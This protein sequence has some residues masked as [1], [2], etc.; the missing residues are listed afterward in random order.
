MA[1]RPRGVKTAQL[2]TWN[3][4][5]MASGGF[6]T[7]AIGL[8]DSLAFGLYND[9]N[10]GS[11]IVLWDLVMHYF[12]FDGAGAT[13]LIDV[14][15]VEGYD[16]NS[17]TKGAPL[18]A[19]A[20]ALAGSTWFEHNYQDFTDDYLYLVGANGMFQWNHDWPLGAIPPGWSL[21]AI[22]DGEPLSLISYNFIWEV[23]RSL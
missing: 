14:G 16:N 17:L 1:V 12:P 19:T 21:V 22:T 9:A 11:W 4:K 6:E 10:D 23:T 15:H 20:A 8:G 13:K 2:P 7:G 3:I 5:N 18:V